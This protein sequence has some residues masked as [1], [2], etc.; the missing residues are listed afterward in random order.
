[1][2]AYCNGVRWF[3]TS[4]CPRELYAGEQP[5]ESHGIRNSSPRFVLIYSGTIPAPGNIHRCEFRIFILD[6]DICK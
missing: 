1:M 4:A 5:C 2:K 6:D 3:R